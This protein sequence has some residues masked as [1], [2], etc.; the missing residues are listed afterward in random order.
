MSRKRLSLFVTIITLLPT[1]RA[2]AQP[3][4]PD[5]EIVILPSVTDSFQSIGLSPPAQDFGILLAQATSY[6]GVDSGT[7]R[8]NSSFN[9]RYQESHNGAHTTADEVNV[10]AFLASLPSIG[11]PGESGS[12]SMSTSS[13]SQIHNLEFLNE[14]ANPVVLVQAVTNNGTDPIAV[15]P[16][17]TA[18]RHAVIA[19]AEGSRYDLVH[20]NAETIHYVVIEAGVYQL[21]NGAMLEAGLAPMTTSS[22]SSSGF[23]TI[24]AHEYAYYGDAAIIAQPQYASGPSAGPA[25][26]GTRVRRNIDGSGYMSSFDVRFMLDD[27]V[28]ASSPETMD[29]WVGYLI[30][31]GS[32]PASYTGATGSN[33]DF[34]WVDGLSVEDQWQEYLAD[35]IDSVCGESEV[36]EMLEQSSGDFGNSTFGAGY[37]VQVGISDQSSNGGQLWVG[38]KGDADVTIFGSSKTVLDLGAE[39]TSEDGSQSNRGWLEVLG[40]TVFDQSLSVAV[41]ESYDKTFLTATG[42][43]YGVTVTGKAVGTIGISGSATAGASGISV[44]ATPYASLTGTGSASIGL[45]C[46]SAGVSANLTL[47]GVDVPV[48]GN[49]QFLAGYNSW[50][51]DSSVVLSTLDGTFDLDVSYCLGSDSWELFSWSGYSTTI[52]LISDSGCL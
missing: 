3:P 31:G 28:E 42:T 18:P 8:I 7:I 20:G 10:V 6:D 24:N 35:T 33:Q 30:V 25:Y 16:A 34:G 17:F 27:D 23:T 36:E 22:Y 47:L 49:V 37:Q 38:G 9:A 46:A 2:I 19:M 45:F 15:Y 32:Q 29:S 48:N 39:A 1:A 13:S 43:F 51:F 14:Y 4:P 50:D 26:A 41:D 44:N 11:V 5:M 21:P 52:P 12:F 40:L